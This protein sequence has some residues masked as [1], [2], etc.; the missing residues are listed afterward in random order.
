MSRKCYINTTDPD[1]PVLRLKVGGY[2]YGFSVNCVRTDAREWLAE[3]FEQQ[4]TQVHNRAVEKTRK[5]IQKEARKLFGI[6]ECK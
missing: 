2:S 6:G 1:F 4:M 5:E 3:I